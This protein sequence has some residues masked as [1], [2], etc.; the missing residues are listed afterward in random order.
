MK[1]GIIISI[2]LMSCFIIG[3]VAYNNYKKQKIADE[4]ANEFM[5]NMETNDLDWSDE[6]SIVN[7]LQNAMINVYE[8]EIS[9][10][11]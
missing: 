1:K 11:K 7:A 6:E 2:I 4:I 5:K 10:S 3:I 9:D 8:N